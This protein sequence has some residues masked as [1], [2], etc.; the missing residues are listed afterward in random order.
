[1]EGGGNEISFTK[2]DT[3]KTSMCLSCLA[4]LMYGK[5]YFRIS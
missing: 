1:M 5:F 3:K 2:T 4:F